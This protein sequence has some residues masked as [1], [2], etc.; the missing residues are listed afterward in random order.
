MN[1]NFEKLRFFWTLVA[2]TIAGLLT[3]YIWQSIVLALFGYIL[4]MLT[5]LFE[6]DRW[7]NTGADINKVPYASGLWGRIIGHIVKLRNQQ[8]RSK[9]SYQKLMIRFNEIIRSFPYPTVVVNGNSEIQ[10]MSKSAGKILGLNR[11]KDIGIRIGNI[12]RNSEFQE[13]LAKS[14]LSEFQMV[15]PSSKDVVLSIAISKLTKD[16]RILSIRDVSD[17]RRLE[18]LRKGFIA[19]ASHELR[20]P[21]TIIN[22][23]LEM[24]ES[25]DKLSDEAK[26]MV[27]KAYKQSKRMNILITDL[28][29]L[30][31]LENSEM[32]VNKFVEVDVSMLIQEISA[33]IKNTISFSGE[34]QLDLDKNLFIHGIYSQLYSI[35]FNL[36]ENA[37]KY[38]KDSIVVNWQL[39]DGLPTFEVI[40]NGAGI[41]QIDQARL[42]EPFFRTQDSQVAEI[43]G[44]GL[45][46]SIVHQAAIKNKA[47]L[48]IE[49]EKDK[50]SIFRVIFES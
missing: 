27:D 3:G 24:L 1:S 43:Q 40:D 12:L 23:Y 14:E 32:Q 28:L 26:S 25:H 34:I 11:K 2:A 44:T 41:S 39:V 50:G 6:L 4:W 35:V 7:L 46:L 29:T 45:G 47:R 8:G 16:T 42:I 5:K 20:T 36:M 17:R 22:G 18:K 19:N 13:M 9:K 30:S 33:N 31:S 38:S 21:L 15:S 48:D 37:A 10:W 49:S